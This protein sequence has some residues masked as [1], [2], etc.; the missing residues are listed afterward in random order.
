MTWGMRGRPLEERF[1]ARV[2]RADKA[3]CWLWTGTTSSAGYGEIKHEGVRYLAHR[4]AWTLTNGDLP[5]GAVVMHACDRREC[6]NPSH[7]AAGS[8]ALNSAD[9]VK[10]GRSARGEKVHGAKLTTEQVREVRARRAAGE[11]LHSL[12]R[13]LGVS[14]TTLKKLTNR[15]TW[16]HVA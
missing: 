5:R 13:T 4:L 14:R 10:K 15:Q 7:L 16:K 6:C 12:S 2:R 11:S 3:S 9:M 1:W 8:P